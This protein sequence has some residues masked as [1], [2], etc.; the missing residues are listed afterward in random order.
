MSD[1]NDNNDINEKLDS[2]V[3]NQMAYLF[4]DCLGFF[5][6]FGKILVWCSAEGL[7][8]RPWVFPCMC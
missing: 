5:G 1:I 4:T 3:I 7:E 6:N 8:L 2:S